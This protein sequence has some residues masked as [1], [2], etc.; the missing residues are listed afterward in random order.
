MKLFQICL[1]ALICAGSALCACAIASAGPLH[2]GVLLPLSGQ[3]GDEG[4]MA[5]QGFELALS[6][7]GAW[8]K[9][10]LVLHYEDTHGDTTGAINAYRSLRSRAPV[11]VI[12]TW[13]SGIGVA[14]MPL[15]D[16]DKVLQMGIA[17]A[18][19]KY[20][21]EGDFSF[22]LF[23]SA[24]QESL[25][26]AVVI[27]QMGHK[28]V[29]IFAVNND[30]GLGLSQGLKQAFA[31][32]GGSVAFEEFIEPGQSDFRA[33]L[34]RLRSKQADIIYL[35]SYPGA[36]ALLMR[37]A[38]ELGIQTPFMLSSAAIGDRNFLKLSGSAG[39][40]ALV[41]ISG[42]VYEETTEPAARHF[43]DLFRAA[44][45]E[46]VGPYQGMSAR[47]FDALHLVAQAARKCEPVSAFCLK[48]GIEQVRDYQGAS[49]LI[50]IDEAGDSLSSF[51]LFVIRDGEF[52]PMRVP[53]QHP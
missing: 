22:R 11:Q 21:V 18:T 20:R 46:K 40:G 5:R 27:S 45:R 25:Y 28:Q 43:V 14:L 37:Q 34:I 42:A 9:E 10:N 36:G 23:P 51:G 15:V 19:P 7:L 4:D 30:Y 39:E 3:Y 6:D 24:V 16:R 47:S 41:A 52:R 13:G 50:T 35:I 12:F 26:V 17:T 44:F 29:S 8:G 1:R 48:K 33:Q 49:G 32:Q 53:A 31:E 38:R 2:C